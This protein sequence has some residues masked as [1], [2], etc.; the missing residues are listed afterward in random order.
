MRRLQVLTGSLVLLA[1][2]IAGLA[3][4]GSNAANSSTYRD[5][6]LLLGA[7]PD[8]VQLSGATVGP[9][10][11]L[12]GQSQKTVKLQA[13]ESTEPGDRSQH[14]TLSVTVTTPGSPARKVSGGGTGTAPVK[15]PLVGSPT[16]QTNTVSWAAVFD[17][18]N[19]PC[20]SS[21]TPQNTNADPHPFVIKV[22]GP[23]CVVPNVVG[24][25]LKAAKKAI[26]KANC[27]VGK[28]NGPTKSSSK[29]IKQKPKPGIRLAP[30][31][32]VKLTTQ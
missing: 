1:M 14:T 4:T 21:Q 9:G 8:Y 7:D 13:W 28:I 17:N 5:C 22:T 3:V 25:K 16:G 12:A 10:G 31:S 24:K 11:K 26:K 15:L 20:P 32:K 2:V 29:V 27:K 30:G 18:G 23:A 6:S 19:H